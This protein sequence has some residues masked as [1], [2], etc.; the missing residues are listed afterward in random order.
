MG[1]SWDLIIW[2]VVTGPCFFF[3]CV[4]VFP[5]I[6]NNPTD[7]YISE[8]VKPATRLWLCIIV[9]YSY[10]DYDSHNDISIKSQLS[11]ISISQLLIIWSIFAVRICLYHGTYYTGHGMMVPLDWAFHRWR[12]NRCM[13]AIQ[14]PFVGYEILTFLDTPSDI[15]SLMDIDS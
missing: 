10:D 5:Y 13:L 3:L 6:G 2:L 15:D 11:S 4:C 9:W 14:S 8:G 1:I 12:F 7:W